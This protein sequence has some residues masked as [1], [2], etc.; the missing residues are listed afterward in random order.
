MI[1]AARASP[2][3]P[4]AWQRL[5]AAYEWDDLVLPPRQAD[6]LRA[7]GDEFSARFGDASGSQM[8]RSRGGKRGILV[9]LCGPARTG[10]TMAAQ[11]LAHELSLGVIEADLR[12]ALLRERWRVARLFTIAARLPTVLVFDHFDTLIEQAKEADGSD[13][14]APATDVSDLLERSSAHAGVVMFATR[15]QPI[16]TEAVLAH[17]DHVI[18]FP[19][20]DRAA[21]EEIQRRELEKTGLGEADTPALAESGRQA[22]GIPRGEMTS[23]AVASPAGAAAAAAAWAA[24][25]R[26]GAVAAPGPSGDRSRPGRRDPLVG[27]IQAWRW[28]IA[29]LAGIVVAAT[30]GLLLADST[31]STALP[32]LARRV[33]AGP[34]VVSY[35]SS[36]Q[37]T[38]PAFLGGFAL[39]HSVDLS[40]RHSH[41]Q[42]LMLGT[43]AGPGDLLLPARM[44][45]A[46]S[47]PVAGQMVRLGS[48]WFYR[49]PS[50][51]LRRGQGR[52]SVYA[53]TTTAGVVLS[54][55]R[56]PSVEFIAACER[57]LGALMLRPGVHTLVSSPGY[58]RSLS[59]V[60]ARLDAVRL[61][62]SSELAAA[63]TT[64]AQ[65]RVEGRLASA[66]AQAGS[67]IA[68]LKAGP[69]WAANA[70]LASALKMTAGAYAAMARAASQQDTVAYRAA[71]ASLAAATAATDS[72][73]GDLAQFGYRVG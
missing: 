32:A 22:R 72:A 19:L 8:Q 52:A 27:A 71:S 13:P 10:K 11:A 66:S 40:P 46:P 48:M 21:R 68:R 59:D 45:A 5:P 41:Q 15:L 2:V 29:G 38:A 3:P 51:L 42:L 4:R 73:L 7:L 70:R 57:V 17:F 63:Q 35:P 61:I 43:S 26:N 33:T 14:A 24:V 55:C 54:I 36:W 34:V 56:P 25:A 31:E 47:H 28:V 23:D 6:E 39:S 20:P 16:A 12:S 30:L 65:A 37:M 69:A 67:A 18:E 60:I 44:V 64:N 49:F 58:A 53:L 62:A 50:V 9:L 1:G